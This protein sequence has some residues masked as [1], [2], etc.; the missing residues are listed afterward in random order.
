VVTRLLTVLSRSLARID[1]A[2][3]SHLSPHTRATRCGGHAP[4]PFATS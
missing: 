1:R 4:R 2:K 3:P